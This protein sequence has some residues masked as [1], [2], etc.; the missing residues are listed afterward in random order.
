MKRAI[1]PMRS[2]EE[3]WS[4]SDDREFD[5]LGGSEAIIG[6]CSTDER[7]GPCIRFA[8]PPA[9]TERWCTAR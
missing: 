4:T 5:G 8:R 6:R 9:R 1:H 7:R 2:P 3:N